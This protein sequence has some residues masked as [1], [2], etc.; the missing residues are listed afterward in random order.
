MTGARATT[1]MARTA[2]AVALACSSAACGDGTSDEEE[3]LAALAASLRDDATFEDY[4]IAD[5]EATCVAETVVA[6]LGVDRV[7]E[8]GF[9]ESGDDTPDAVDF[10]A[11]SDDEITSIAGA[12]EN[13]IADVEAL[14]VDAI[15]EGITAEPDPSFPVSDTEARCV[16]QGVADELPLSRLVLVGIRADQTG[17]DQ[18]DDITDEE[19]AAFTDAFVSCIDVRA[20]LLEG[21]AA[22]GI[23]DT[24]LACLDENISDDAIGALFTAGFRGD[25]P[26]TS[27]MEIL[28][29]AIDA[30]F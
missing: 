5:E 16:A 10:A 30:C 23:P 7:I 28:A 27:A 24:A 25:D 22:E 13:C 19:A 15:T 8:I 20:V 26:E 4:D 3:V 9:T 29:P 21:F 17:A 1:L 18:F 2:L 6:D 14:L 11:L 12:M